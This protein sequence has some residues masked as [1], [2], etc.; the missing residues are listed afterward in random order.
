MTLGDEG[1]SGELTYY[2]TIENYPS[3]ISPT[4]IKSPSFGLKDTRWHLTLAHDYEW[5]FLRIFRETDNG[6]SEVEINVEFSFVAFEGYKMTVE[7]QRRLFRIGDFSEMD[8]KLS[9]LHVFEL[10]RSIFI[11]KD[12][13]TIRCRLFLLGTDTRKT[14]MCFARTRMGN[15]WKGFLWTIRNFSRLSPGEEVQY[16]AHPI[17]KWCPSMTLIFRNAPEEHILLQLMV[18][19]DTS[20]A[21]SLLF[22]VVDGCKSHCYHRASG[23]IP[24]SEEVILYF[25]HND[26]WKNKVSKLP[27]D[28][29]TLKFVLLMC[30][31]PLWSGI[32]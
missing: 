15:E 11:P 28:V 25:K 4:D 13:L 18:N 29:L 12:A 21:Y 7:R 27:N 31:G 32:E 26:D 24:A 30:I 5:L 20:V 17:A 19:E 10:K 22:N 9:T 6:P 3:P 2:W 14:Q 8:E 16:N 1:F 23:S